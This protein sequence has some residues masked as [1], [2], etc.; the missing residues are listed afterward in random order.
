[1]FVFIRRFHSAAL[2]ASVSLS[3]CTRIHFDLEAFIGSAAITTHTHTHMIA[4][5]KPGI[6]SLLVY[7]VTFL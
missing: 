1:M 4:V 6:D 2:T 7:T 3:L 5:L